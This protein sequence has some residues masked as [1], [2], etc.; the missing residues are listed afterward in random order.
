MLGTDN[1]SRTQAATSK[2]SLD[3]IMRK[4]NAEARAG[5]LDAIAMY[6]GSPY[7]GYVGQGA[8][9]VRVRRRDREGRAGEV[10]M[11]YIM[12]PWPA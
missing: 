8:G 11:V 6:N 7:V 2:N 10:T 3:R 9:G 5:D 12:S 4:V 1:G